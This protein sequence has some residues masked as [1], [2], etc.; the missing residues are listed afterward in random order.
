LSASNAGVEPSTYPR[1]LREEAHEQAAMLIR[2]GLSVEEARAELV[3]NRI[4]EELAVA[5]LADVVASRRST[6]RSTAIGLVAVGAV[7][8]AIGAVVTASSFAFAGEGGS[9]V[10]TTGALGSGAASVLVGAWIPAPAHLISPC[11]DRWPATSPDCRDA[12]RFALVYARARLLAS[13]E[14]SAQDAAA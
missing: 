4:P 11:K 7:L 2:Q 5:A 6:W 3:D 14:P 9:Y 8:L 13:D 12:P 10:V 1:T